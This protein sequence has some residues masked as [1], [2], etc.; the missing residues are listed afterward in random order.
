MFKD[1][2][3][4][5]TIQYYKFKDPIYWNMHLHFGLLRPVGIIGLRPVVL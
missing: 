3:A 4:L 5:G 1:H 2:V